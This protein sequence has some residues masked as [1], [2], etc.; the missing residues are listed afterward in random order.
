MFEVLLAML[1]TP[2]DYHNFL[3]L[4]FEVLLA[5]L[6]PPPDYHNIGF[7]NVESWGKQR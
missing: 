1:Q 6:K 4:V 5:M 2:P 3:C 7:G